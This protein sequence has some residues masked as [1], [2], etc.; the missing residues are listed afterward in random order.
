MESVRE[1]WTSEL[2]VSGSLALALYFLLSCLCSAVA[3]ACSSCLR[4]LVRVPGNSSTGVSFAS[5]ESVRLYETGDTGKSFLL[6]MYQWC[7]CSCVVHALYLEGCHVTNSGQ[8]PASKQC[9]L[10]AAIPQCNSI[11][12]HAGSS[13]FARA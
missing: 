5:A 12:W 10:M 6:S 1:C 8:A 2:S 3:L 9:H 13:A 11:S 7:C 4:V